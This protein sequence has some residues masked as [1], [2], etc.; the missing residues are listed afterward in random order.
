[1]IAADYGAPTTRERL[2]LIARCDGQ[3]IVWTN[4]TH[5][6]KAKRG[7]QKWRSAAECIDFSDLGNSIFER[8]KPLADA[9]LKRIA[10]GL[11]KYVIESKKPFFVNSAVP[12]I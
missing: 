8:S 11:Q 7:Q 2:F 3:P 4:A 12:F 5:F 9:T 10:R 1:I 6:K